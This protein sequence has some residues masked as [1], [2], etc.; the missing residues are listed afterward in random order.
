MPSVRTLLALAASAATLALAMPSP[1]SDVAPNNV[2]GVAPNHVPG[3]ASNVHDAQHGHDAHNARDAYSGR[4]A[5]NGHGKDTHKKSENTTDST[6][7]PAK[8]DR[9]KFGH[10]PVK[11]PPQQKTMCQ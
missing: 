3:V 4:D 9:W 5:H 7:S 1:A 11:L 6:G 8:E 10:G 2:T